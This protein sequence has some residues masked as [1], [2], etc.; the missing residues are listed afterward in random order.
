MKTKERIAYIATIIALG[1]I[2]SAFIF[3]QPNTSDIP[4][5]KDLHH[6]KSFTELDTFLAIDNTSEQERVNVKEANA[7]DI[8][9]FVCH[10]F[11]IMFRD[12]AYKSGYEVI[13]LSYKTPRGSGH[14]ENLAVVYITGKTIRKVDNRYPKGSYIVQ[15]DAEHDTY[16]IL[17]YRSQETRKWILWSGEAK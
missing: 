11:A 4:V 14:K 15:I 2:L 6:F 12:N 10:H 3:Y 1:L 7:R 13:T 9:T 8:P 5:S 17:L 16:D